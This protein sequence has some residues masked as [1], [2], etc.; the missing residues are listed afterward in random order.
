MKSFIKMRAQ[1]FCLF[2]YRLSEGFY[3]RHVAE[4]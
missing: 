2:I 1:V 3:I 4:N